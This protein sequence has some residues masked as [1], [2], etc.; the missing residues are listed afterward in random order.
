MVKILHITINKFIIQCPNMIKYCLK[1]LWIKI[2]I[3]S[4]KNGTLTES[5]V[6]IMYPFMECDKKGTQLCGIGM[7]NLQ[8]QSNC[9]NM[10]G[11]GKQIYFTKYLTNMLQL[12]KG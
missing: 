10:P 12:F 7:K 4:D 6:N 1:H 5:H 3:L 2:K 9:E 11:K 8:N